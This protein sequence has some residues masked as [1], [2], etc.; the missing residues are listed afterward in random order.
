MGDF[1]LLEEAMGGRFVGGMQQSRKMILMRTPSNEE[2]RVST[3]HLFC[4]GTGL[5]STELLVV[6]REAPLGILK[7]PRLLQRQRVPLK[8]ATTGH[9]TH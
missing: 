6:G 9:G 1:A 5:H 2:Y 8:K 3:G 7:Q 4:G